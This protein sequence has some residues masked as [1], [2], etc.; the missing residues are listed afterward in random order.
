MGLAGLVGLALGSVRRR[1]PDPST[2][3]TLAR[4][5]ATGACQCRQLAAP[6]VHRS[7]QSSE[8]AERGG[9]GRSHTTA[10]TGHAARLGLD[11]GHLS[12]TPT[13]PDPF[14]VPGPRLDRLPRA[15]SL[16]A[17]G[18]LA[19]CGYEIS[20]P[21][22]PAVY[23]LVAGRRLLRVQVKTTTS[24]PDARGSCGSPGPATRS[25]RTTRTTSMRSQSSTGDLRPY[26]IP[27]SVVGGLQ[28]IHVG[29]DEDYRLD[30]GQPTTGSTTQAQPIDF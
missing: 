22:E 3:H 6:A 14:S 5:V 11:T 4:P 7:T 17:A 8:V 9:V 23:D 26:L 1:E 2:G 21:L 10:L 15:G 28:A 18:W 16:L 25:A 24:V 30:Q 29:A 12:R 27:A 20:W 13:R 19:L